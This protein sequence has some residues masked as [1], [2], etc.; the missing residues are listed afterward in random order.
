MNY[1][2][3]VYGGHFVSTMIALAFE[4][5]DV[6]KIVNQAIESMP[7]K[8]QY[9][10]T[11]KDVIDF[12]D[13]NPDDFKTCWKFINDKYLTT[14]VDCNMLHDNFISPPRLTALLSQSA[15]SMATGTS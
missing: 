9:Y 8:S 14:A 2:D 12:H 13:K 15:C 5:N 3:G 4:S 11:I 1:G 6:E 7:R 10:R